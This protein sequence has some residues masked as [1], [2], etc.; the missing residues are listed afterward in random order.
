MD[1]LAQTISDKRAEAEGLRARLAVLEAELSAL[2]LADRLRPVTTYGGDRPSQG[3]SARKGGGRRPGDISQ[4]WRSILRGVYQLGEPVDYAM[5]QMIAQD[6]GQNI[7]TSSVRD[8]V[9]NLVKTGLMYGD[10]Q[11]GFTVTEDAAERFDFAKKNEPPRGGSEIGEV[12]ASPDPAQEP[13]HPLRLQA[14]D[15]HRT[16][17]GRGG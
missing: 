14:A 6:Q 13:G 8:R 16:D 10:V 7:E 1:K 5:I 4:V 11:T 3:R 9:R 17:A 12:G 15:L 2:E